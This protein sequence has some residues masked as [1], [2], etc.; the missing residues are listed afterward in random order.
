[1]QDEI[2]KAL[3]ILKRGGI[4]L[5]PTDTVWG[6]GCDATNVDAVKK[7]YQLKQREETKSM[8]VLVEHADRIGRYVRDVPE[9]AWQLIEVNDE[10]MTIIYPGAINLAP[11]LIGQD[12][13]IGIRIVQDEFCQKLIARLNRPLVSTS[14]NI[15]GQ[16]SPAIFSEVSDEIKNGVD[17]IVNWRQDDSVISSSSSIIKIGLGGEIEIIRK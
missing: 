4:I 7:T 2:F 14:A 6:I 12:N 1:M 5:Y 13:T 8:L 16:P 10:P 3:A 15:S 11:N 9:M 17:Y